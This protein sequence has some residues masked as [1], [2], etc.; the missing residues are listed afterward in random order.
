MKKEYNLA[1]VKGIKKGPVVDAKST[2]VQ[3]SLRMDLDLISWLQSEAHK[4][5]IG[6]Q[7]FLNMKIREAMRGSVDDHIREIVRDELRLK[8]A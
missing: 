5:G 4:I 3:I 2:K 1:K 7:T 8:G 6:Y